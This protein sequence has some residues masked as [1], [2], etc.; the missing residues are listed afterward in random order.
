MALV[1]SK[2]E[3]GLLKMIKL[4]K[5]ISA[6]ILIGT[7]SV[8]LIACT[9]KPK[10]V[11]VVEAPKPTPVPAPTPKPKPTVVSKPSLPVGIQPGTMQDFIVNIG[12]R[13]FFDTDMSDI[14][15]DAKPILDAQSSWLARYSTVMIRIEGNADERGTREYNLALGERRAE[16]VKAY[17]MSRGVPASR[18][19]TIS[20]GKE[21]PIASGSDEASWQQNRNARTSITSGAK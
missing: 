2:I 16:S 21:N 20:Y 12:D 17:L 1:F 11:A 10:P 14:R 13:V 7:A 3:L 5:L 18:I 6:A 15:S 9:S 4:S 8:T 19:A